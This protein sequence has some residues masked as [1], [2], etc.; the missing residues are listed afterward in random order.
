MR[1]NQHTLDR[2]SDELE[3]SKLTIRN[4]REELMYHQE[5]ALADHART[6]SEVA[7]AVAAHQA[8]VASREHE[9]LARFEEGQRCVESALMRA[10]R[11]AQMEEMRA[12]T[13]SSE[14]ATLTQGASQDAMSQAISARRTVEW[15]KRRRTKS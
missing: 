7:T 9:V 1:T 5:T 10:R 15:T 3:H 11:A 4:L 2:R 13:A 14:R 6:Q 12:I 8:R